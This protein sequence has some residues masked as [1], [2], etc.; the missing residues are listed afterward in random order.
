M[1]TGPEHR[2][3]SGAAA[4]LGVMAADGAGLVPAQCGRKGGYGFGLGA[5]IG[6]W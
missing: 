6:E 1:N 4:V 3:A 5:I 2:G